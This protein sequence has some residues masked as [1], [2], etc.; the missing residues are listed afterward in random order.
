MTIV[1]LGWDGLDP[2]LLERWGL[3]DAFGET[4]IAAETFSNPSVGIPHTREL[5]PTII[6]GLTP[7]EHG[8]RVTDP[9]SD[10][11]AWESTW[12]DAASRLANGIVPHGVRA[13]IGKRLRERGAELAVHAPDYYRAHGIRTV[14]DGR[15]ARAITVPNYRLDQPA[16]GGELDNPRQRQADLLAEDG[17]LWAPPA[18]AADQMADTRLHPTP[19]LDEHFRAKASKRLGVVEAA[20]QREYDLVFAWMGYIDG[21]GHIAPLVDE[22]GW[23]R[24]HY[25]HAARDTRRIR[26]LLGDDD[27]LLCVSDHGLQDGHHTHE[28]AVCG[29]ADVVGDVADLTDVAAAIGRCTPRRPAVDGPPV[30]ER[31]RCAG[32]SGGQTTDAVREHLEDLGYA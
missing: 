22:A 13:R 21:V 25:E 16:G 29:P 2:E 7:A 18:K 12:L 15:R 17:P 20:L 14:F 28:A 19:V 26:A 10:A 5:W 4:L 32:E 24:R 6:T 9:D 1:V 11:V 30:R 27:T 3:A 8:I 23:Q 31:Y